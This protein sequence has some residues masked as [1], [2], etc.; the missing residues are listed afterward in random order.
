MVLQNSVNQTASA[1]ASPLIANGCRL[2]LYASDSQTVFGENGFGTTLYYGAYRS[3]AFQAYDTTFNRWEQESFAT[4]SLSI[5]IPATA[6]SVNYDVFILSGATPSLYLEPWVSGRTYITLQDGVPVHASNRARLFIGSCRAESGVVSDTPAKRFLWNFFNQCPKP[7][8]KT[9][10][11]TSWVY[12]SNVWRP[13]NNST[14]NRIEVFAGLVGFVDLT[15]TGR[16]D[17]TGASTYGT[18]AIGLDSTTVPTSQYGYSGNNTFAQMQSIRYA[19]SLPEG[20]HY[21]QALESTFNNTAITFIGQS[22][23]LEGTWI[24]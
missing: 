20:Y 14:A 17:A 22:C 1:F 19:R 5:A 11:A 16:F 13:W 18:L 12:A 24:C 10:S 6:G 23:G 8:L 7:L 21:L 2:S 9:E 15:F 3:K 4:T